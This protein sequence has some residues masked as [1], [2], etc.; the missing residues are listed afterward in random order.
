VGRACRLAA[1]AALA[2]CGGYESTV[3]PVRESLERGDKAAALGAVDKRLGVESASQVPEKFSEE[4]ALLLLERG[5]I[6]H[7]LQRYSDSARDLQE[8][9]KHLEL[10][11]LSKDTAGSI[12]KYLY[13]DT[14]TVY[15]A[16]PYEKLL[17]ST[18]N[19]LNYLCL[20]DLEN[21]RVEARRLTVMQDYLKSALPQGKARFGLGSYLA[22]YAYEQSGR[23]DE[24]LRYYDEALEAQDYPSLREPVIRL[25]RATGYR[26]PRIEKILQGAPAQPR[27]PEGSDLLVVLQ[28]GL[29]AKK[30]PERIPIGLAF[31]V[32]YDVT[33]P[34]YRMTEEQRRNADIVVAK[35][36]LKWINFPV[37]KKTARRVWPVALDVDGR[38]A[39]VEPAMDVTGRAIDAYEDM[40]PLLIVSAVT[41]MVARAIAGEAAGYG[42]KKATGQGVLGLLAGLAT[43]ATLIAADRPDTRSWTS[44]ASEISLARLRLPP[45]SH[46]VQAQF[47]GPWGPRSARA[48]ANV[49]AGFKVLS[50]V[51]TL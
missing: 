12:G 42:V 44:V 51:E 15:K 45:G 35:S 16:P 5:A 9:E 34:R 19:L 3:R 22:G 18:L 49:P 40:K 28:A 1:L 29:V 31:A 13:S 43:E 48:D 2:G 4:T 50:F 21:A 26:S 27:P 47:S 30:E 37:L 32:A 6:L 39:P 33:N 46:R 20:S 36:L 10:L 7:G 17:L 8:A 14:A 24:A 25:A 41:R 38:D 23:A 11:D